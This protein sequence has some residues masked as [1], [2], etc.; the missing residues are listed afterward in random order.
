MTKSNHTVYSI[1]LQHELHV[2]GTTRNNESHNNECIDHRV[3]T[4]VTDIS[5]HHK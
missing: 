5:S 2:K 1:S 3:M 4:E